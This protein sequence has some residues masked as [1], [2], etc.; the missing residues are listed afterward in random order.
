MAYEEL[1]TTKVYLKKFLTWF[2]DQ[3]GIIGTVIGRVMDTL[4]GE[5][6]HRSLNK[7]INKKIY[8]WNGAKRGINEK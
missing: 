4:T 1:L 3:S 7:V 8:M 6:I 5:V 2:Y